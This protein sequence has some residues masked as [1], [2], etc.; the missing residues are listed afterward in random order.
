MVHA[1]EYMD[2]DLNAYD[3]FHETTRHPNFAPG[4]WYT[5]YRKAW[6]SFY[7]FDYMR[8]VLANANPEN[9]WNIFRNFIWYKNSVHIEGGHPMIHGLFRMKDRTDRRPGFTIETRARHFVRRVRE[10]RRLAREWIALL[11][12]MEE[13]W[14]QTRKRS[15]AELRLVFEL[16]RAREGVNRNLRTAELQLAYY[17]AKV[18]VPGLRVPSRLALVFRD[19]NFGLAKRV[20]YTRADVQRFW[21]KTW[22]RWRR[23]KIFLIPPHKVCLHFLRDAQLMCI[24]AL[25]LLRADAEP[26]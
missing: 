12:E 6:R 8:Q 25:A 2:P 14:L 11:L 9:Y 15:K 3:S 7:S 26:R 24:F 13:L 18:H 16:K 19:L 20:T 5:T 23:R 17:R 4:E 10:I 1:G 21:N 22:K